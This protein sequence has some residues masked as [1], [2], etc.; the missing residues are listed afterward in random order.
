MNKIY[1]AN[2]FIVAE[3]PAPAVTVPGLVRWNADEDTLDLYANGV[4]YQLGQEISPLVKNQTGST[5][6]NGTPVR[7]AGSVGAS[8][9]ILVAPVIAD[10]SFP[11]SYSLGIATQDI[12]NGED[13]HV[14]WFGK[15]RQIDTTGTPYGEAW[16]DGDLLYVSPA[17]AGNLTNV[18]PQAP[19][20]QI[21][22]GVVILAHATSGSI[23]A[24]P[25]WRGKM[26]DLDDVNGTP[27]N[28]SGQL[29]V[30]DD[31]NQYFDFTSNISDFML[32]GQQLAVT[33]APAAGEFFTSYDSVTGLFS[34]ATPINSNDN[35]FVNSFTFSAGTLAAI[36]P[37]QTNP[38]INLDGRYSLLGHT[39]LIADITDFTDNSIAWDAHIVSDG[40]DHTFI[41]QDVTASSTPTFSNVISN[42]NATN[43]N[44]LVRLDQMN[45]AIAGLDW[46]DSVI[47]KDLTTPPA[48]PIADDRYIISSVA[49]GDWLTHEDEIA[50][51]NGSSWDFLTPNE[52][53]TVWVEDQDTNFTYNGTLW[54]EFG[55][56]V[57]HNN[58]T[59]L[60]GGSPSEYYHLTSAQYN[61]LTNGGDSTSHT[62]TFASLTSKPTTISGFGITD[63]YTKVEADGK[64]LLNTT[65]TLTGNLTVT[66]DLINTGNIISS[67][68]GKS[69]IGSA[70]DATAKL[71]IS[72]GDPINHT[73]L[74]LKR[75]AIGGF[76]DIKFTG[77]STSDFSL[78]SSII[79]YNP[80]EKLLDFRVF[81]GTSRMTI[82]GATGVVDIKAS[83][84]ATSKD[85]GALV[86]SAGGLGVEQDIFAGGTILGSNLSGTNT[87]DNSV[88]TLY[89]GLVSNITTNL[90]EG[91]STIATVDVNS[92]DGTNATL[93][94]ASTIRAGVMSKAKFDEV[95]I[96]NGK[97][98]NIVQTSIVG[99]TGT[100]VEYN[101]S[102]T[103][104]EFVFVG[105]VYTKVEADGKYLLN[106]TD[107]LTGNLTVT[108]NI[109]SQGAGNNSFVGNVGIGTTSPES[110]LH[111]K[112]SA[113]L[114]S[115][116]SRGAESL[117]I[118]ITSSGT[119]LNS[120]TDYRFIN[121]GAEKAR[122]TNSGNFGI[123]TTAPAAKLDILSP[124]GNNLRLSYSSLYYWIV[125]R[126][127][128]GH[129]RFINHQNAADSTKF[130]ILTTGEVGV[131]TTSP[132]EKL[133]VV[134][135][136]KF[137][138]TVGIDSATNAT[139]KDTGALI[140]AAGGLGV[141][142]DIY[143]GGKVT[144]D[145]YVSNATIAEIDTTGD[146]SLIT[147]EY[148]DNNLTAGLLKVSYTLSSAQ[149]LAL[150]TTPIEVVSAQ[151][152]G[153]VII[154]KNIVYRYNF[155]TTAY[156]TQ[157][158]L[159]AIYTGGS[160]DLQIIS[161]ILDQTSDI[162]KGSG[163]SSVAEMDENTGI[164][165]RVPTADPTAGSGTVDVY[166]TYEI[167]T[168]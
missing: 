137:S 67:G 163:L 98:S 1:E 21:F 4:T 82:K 25:S 151:G 8:G 38:T 20:P 138:G 37:N 125:E 144:A 121:N 41:D 68:G 77:L 99:I 36:I 26:T 40:S 28:T 117:N 19:N 13:G 70:L 61:D 42:N 133:D 85:T 47:D 129:L 57:S 44:H 152:A 73:L 53:W 95:V 167:L 108:E 118:G 15:V 154:V 65:D 104:G 43:N 123:G 58:T 155:I 130:S 160:T 90:S 48:G 56:T 116:V 126:G 92:S 153:T 113:D 33:K 72:D 30:W 45:S 131:G 134:G 11:S 165:I 7:F 75:T 142:Q 5:I 135:N 124:V 49:T 147:K 84:N 143:V 102:V 9:R 29:V 97:V 22:M 139:S 100:K 162:I 86:L 103:D 63:A 54:V 132:S 164:S 93:Q 119:F 66:G 168:L 16:A 87:G 10:G 27:L 145:E 46:Q 18:K 81:D 146:T 159:R 79:R 88:N 122:I 59:G 83:T 23:F 35:D 96:N 55:S 150:N 128:S 60:Q 62:H 34:S 24:R 105:D 141:E 76:V 136:G 71:T 80:S 2:S 149:I 52:G 156:S 14:T 89:S 161:N 109:I 32:S 112:S 50:Q 69:N 106:T 17:T 111:L 115:R 140:I 39:H 91:T 64:Y 158:G 12:L 107:T 110:I 51:W 120:T 166:V 3:G 127:A 78:S 31:S 101:T 148:L 114:W 74:S 6:S 94:S 157:N